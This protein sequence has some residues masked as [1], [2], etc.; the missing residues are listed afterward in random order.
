MAHTQQTHRHFHTQTL[1]VLNTV[2]LLVVFLRACGEMIHCCP[3]SPV[4]AIVVM[5]VGKQTANQA[6]VS[7]PHCPPGTTGR[8]TD[9]N[10]LPLCSASVERR[11][12]KG[13][14]GTRGRGRRVE[15]AARFGW[16]LEGKKG[17]GWRWRCGLNCY[18]GWRRRCEVMKWSYLEACSAQW[19]GGTRW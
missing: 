9:T 2:W 6:C 12:K 7:N 16:I 8:V 13:G 17:R 10:T 5:L 3:W 11:G 14:G 15:E 4:V 19:G 18:G 1:E